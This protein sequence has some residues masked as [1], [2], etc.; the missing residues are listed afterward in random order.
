MTGVELA[1]EIAESFSSL[2]VTLLSAGELLQDFS[3][4]AQRYV[5]TVMDDLGV[6]VKEGLRVQEFAAASVRLSSGQNLRADVVVKTVGF[7][8]PSMAEEAGFSVDASGRVIVDTYLRS[9]SHKN[10]FA[11]GDAAFAGLRMGCVTAMP[12]G[13]YVAGQI[14]RQLSLTDPK[15]F[16]F[17]FV[18]RCLSLG[19]SRGLI[20]FVDQEDRAGSRLLRGRIA[21][22]VK[23]IVC[24][25]TLWALRLERWMS[26]YHWPRPSKRMSI[27]SR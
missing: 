24:R 5:R 13:A 18:L 17:A 2:Q 9:I 11:I 21:G 3:P 15:P 23:E 12:M 22:V 20:Q 10:V 26:V 4:K 14:K 7:V 27:A 1:T 19:R 6:E 25:Y 16:D 8:V